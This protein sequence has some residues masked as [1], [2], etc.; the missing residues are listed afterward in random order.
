MWKRLVRDGA[1]ELISTLSIDFYNVPSLALSFASP[2]SIITLRSE[3]RYLTP[4]TTKV[5]IVCLGNI[6]RSPMGEAVLRKV[7]KDRDIEI[8]VDSAGTAAYHV[9]EEPDERYVSL[10][11]KKVSLVTL[12]HHRCIAVQDHCHL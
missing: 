1:S 9:N 2:N 11:T 6:C 4:M 10:F 3:D 7:A 8:F 5:L 12:R